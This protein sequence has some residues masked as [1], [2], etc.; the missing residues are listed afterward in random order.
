MGYTFSTY[1]WPGLMEALQAAPTHTLL[2]HFE[3]EN[4]GLFGRRVRRYV[5]TISSLSEQEAR[6]RF[7]VSKNAY[8]E[9]LAIGFAGELPPSILSHLGQEDLQRGCMRPIAWEGFLRTLQAY[10]PDARSSEW[11]P[12]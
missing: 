2:A 11:E 4:R 8:D 7:N 12:V 1:L 5:L 6:Q 10:F 9:Y 3:W